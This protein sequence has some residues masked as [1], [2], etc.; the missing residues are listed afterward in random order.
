MNTT[1]TIGGEIHEPLHSFW[2]PSMLMMLSDKERGD[3]TISVD[4]DYCDPLLEE[5]EGD[6]MEDGASSVD[7]MG[8]QAKFPALIQTMIEQLSIPNQEGK[9]SLNKGERKR[10]TPSNSRLLFFKAHKAILSARCSYFK[11][12]FEGPFSDSSHETIHF[13]GSVD[14]LLVVLRYVYLGMDNALK[15]TLLQE[16]Q[17]CWKCLFVAHE[18]G[19]EG[20]QYQCEWFLMDGYDDLQQLQGL[21]RKIQMVNVPFLKLSFANRAF[22]YLSKESFPSKAV[23]DSV[24]SVVE[25][26]GMED[27][28]KVA[29]H[30]NQ[31]MMTVLMRMEGL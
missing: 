16:K 15:L 8:D 23:Q 4:L 6:F 3:V 10:S 18:Y 9:P 13:R 26:L 29:P 12:L 22:L 1:T 21:A 2:E 25:A 14:A 20:L 5:E 11:T 7:G 24:V 19:M 17:L 30:K 28:F 31:A 27:V